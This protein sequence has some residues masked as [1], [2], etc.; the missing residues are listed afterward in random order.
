VALRPDDGEWRRI[1]GLP[2][3]ALH[4]ASGYFAISLDPPANGDHNVCTYSFALDR[5][6]LDTRVMCR[7]RLAIPAWER[8]ATEMVEKR[9]AAEAAS[10]RVGLG[11]CELWTLCFAQKR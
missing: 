4:S 6:L 10:W 11:V 2:P 7:P 1:Q 3:R 9:P 5:Q 8:E